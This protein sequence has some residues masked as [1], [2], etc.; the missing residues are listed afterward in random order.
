MVHA[1]SLALVLY[2]TANALNLLQQFSWDSL[3]TSYFK[4]YHLFL[5]TLSFFLIHLIL[6]GFQKLRFVRFAFLAILLI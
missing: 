1:Y 2:I 5:P 3:S 4:H 6:A